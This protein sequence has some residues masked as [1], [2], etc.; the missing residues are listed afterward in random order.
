MRRRR[1]E[2]R[3]D[4]TQAGGNVDVELLRRARLNA[5]LRELVRQEG[6]MEATE[7]LGVELQD[8]GAGRGV[9]AG[10]GPREG[11]VGAAAGDRWTTPRTPPVNGSVLRRTE[12]RVAGL[13]ALA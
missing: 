6:R 13:E 7:L 2:T 1:T 4:E 5:M 10:H 9:G 12:E 11:C 8:P 3:A